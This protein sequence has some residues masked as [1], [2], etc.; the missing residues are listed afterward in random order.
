M[1][2][3]LSRDIL[4]HARE[5]GVTLTTAESC[6]GGMVSAAITDVAGS[7]DIFHRGFVTYSNAAKQEMLG[8]RSETLEVHGAVSEEVAREMAEGARK[9]AEADLAVAISGIAGPGGSEHKPEGRVCFAL[10]NSTETI[11]ET[12]D[13]GALGRGNVRAAATHHA[14]KLLRSALSDD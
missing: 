9:A 12:K 13:F 3:V 6:T 4:L 7:S 5:R 2:E 10:A 8:V 14:L 1:T 11:T